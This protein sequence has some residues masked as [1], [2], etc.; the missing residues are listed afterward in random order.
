MITG[1]EDIPRL[2]GKAG[3]VLSM[4]LLAN[5]PQ[6]L[7][8]VAYFMYNALLTHMLIAVEYDNY[9]IERKPLRVS[10]PRGDQRSTYYLSLPYRYSI[11]LL[12]ASALLHWLVSE[13]IFF[14]EIIPF[15]LHG[16]QTGRDIVSCGYSPVAIIFAIVVGSLLVLAAVLLGFRRFRSR[17]PLAVQCSAAIGAACHPLSEGDHDRG[18]ALGPVRWGELLADAGYDI[19]NSSQSQLDPDSSGLGTVA[20]D[21]MEM[22]LLS[23]VQIGTVSPGSFFHC[24]FTSDEVN[25]PS[26]SRLYR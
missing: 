26:T 7:I 20:E 18:H 5:V 1:M 6:L 25:E 3:S 16:V 22:Q 14:V 23:N 4:V 13:S 2:P 21:D 11:P 8:S 24:S 15:D 9:A 10:W 17:M 19:L 12:G